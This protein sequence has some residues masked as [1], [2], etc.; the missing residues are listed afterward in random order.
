M[1][2]FPDL[3]VYAA[4]LRQRLV[5]QPV[6]AAKARDL[7][8]LRTVVPP[9]DALAGKKVETIERIGK[10]LA[11][12]LQG[13][14]WLVI[15]LMVLG[16]LHWRT[17]GKLPK[18]A[19]FSLGNPL[20]TLWLSESGKKRRASVHVVQGRA[21]AQG[22]GRGGLEVMQA[23]EVEFAA[24]LG[25]QRRTLKRAL[26]DPSILSAIGNAYSD[27]ILHRAKL[28]PLQLTTNLDDETLRLL[29]LATRAV[30]QEWLDRLSSEA[31]GG[32]PE[33]V[34]AFRPEMAVHGKFGQ[35]CPVCRAPVQRIVYAD[36]ECNYC[37]KCQ[38]GGRLLADRA[39]SQLL[40]DSWPKRLE[41]K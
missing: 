7:F 33:H 38:C 12:G 6:T 39:L 21:A 41:E 35:P 25:S 29:Y 10:R 30:L 5:G 1:P 9:L 36:N 16:R 26:C 40:K 31:A 17:D 13:D 19:L 32:F 37:A 15:H 24:A 34:T 23:S 2:E 4:A 22:L 18:T 27:E 8:V 14:V 20:G 11:V 28:S 3:E